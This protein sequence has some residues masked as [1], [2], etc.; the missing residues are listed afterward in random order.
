MMTAK[1]FS[2][3]CFAWWLWLGTIRGEN[4]RDWVRQNVKSIRN[5]GTIILNTLEPPPGC[6]PAVIPG[7]PSTVQ[8]VRYQAVSDTRSV[9][10]DM[11]SAKFIYVRVFMLEQMRDMGSMLTLKAVTVMKATI[12]G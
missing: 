9:C 3:Y 5:N 8:K 6:V 12:A 2:T 10:Q 4:S 7:S 11:M 1:R